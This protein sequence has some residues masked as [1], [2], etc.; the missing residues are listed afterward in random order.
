[1]GDKDTQLN[2]PERAASPGIQELTDQLEQLHLD[3]PQ[4][5]AI[6]AVPVVPAVPAAPAVPALLAHPPAKQIAGIHQS[7]RQY[8]PA[9]RNREYQRTLE[10]EATRQANR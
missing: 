6:P 1:M 3:V 5:L 2:I 7:N 4:V 9:N 10:E 8:Q